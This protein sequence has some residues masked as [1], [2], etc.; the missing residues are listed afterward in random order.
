MTSR[1]M[2]TMKQMISAT[3]LATLALSAPA[4][5]N[6]FGFGFQKVGLTETEF[7]IIPRTRT[8]PDGYWC[9][10][11]DYA[12]RTLG[13]GWKQRIYV[14]SGF[15]PSKVTGRPSTIEFSIVPPEGVTQPSGIITTNFTPGDSRTVQRAT[16]LCKRKFY[17]NN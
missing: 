9:A 2:V 8:N 3:L 15:S 12:R 16:G 14:V 7:E 1:K 6:V 11:A 13:V 10:A 4:A 17:N 5:A